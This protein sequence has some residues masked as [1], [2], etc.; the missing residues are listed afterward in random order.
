MVDFQKKAEI[1]TQSWEVIRKLRATDDMVEQLKIINSI[2][3][4]E[5]ARVVIRRLM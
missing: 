4:I 1:N 3:D 5:V 2:T